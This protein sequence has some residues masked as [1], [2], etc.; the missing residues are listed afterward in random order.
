MNETLRAFMDEKIPEIERELMNQLAKSDIPDVLHESM[1]YSVEAGGKRIRPLLVLAV[2]HDLDSDSADAL[3]VAA[4]VEFIHTY[5]LIH[6]DLPCM[7][8]DDFRRGKPT[9]HTVFGEDIATLAGDAMQAM[10]FQAL[11]ELRE[12]NVSD[13][14]E[15]VGLLAK[16]SGA[17]GMVKGQ[18]LDMKGEQRVLP[19]AELEEVHI[20]K[21]GALLSYCIEA[22]AVLAQA[23]EE[24]RTQLRRF[25]KNIGLAFQIQDDILDVTATTEQLGKPANSDTSSE[26]STYPSLLGLD[27]AR[28]QLKERHEEALDALQSIGLGN[29]VLQLLADY[30]IERN[31]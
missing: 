13:A 29:S 21:T 18:V 12:T 2:L 23:T 27:G 11:A 28:A 19:L 3:R 24:Q 7:D 15:L 5:S 31:M 6:D 14:L 10:A 25:S 17:Q 4:S 22:G 8:D 1:T 9:N 30:I 16:A 26:K 20:H